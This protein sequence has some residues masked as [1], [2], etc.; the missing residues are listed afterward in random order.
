[1]ILASD[2][3]PDMVSVVGNSNAAISECSGLFQLV[4]VDKSMVG[5]MAKD[6]G[7]GYPGW[8]VEARWTLNPDNQASYNY[9]KA[10]LDN[11]MT[12][13]DNGPRVHATI[14]VGGF[15]AIPSVWPNP[16]PKFQVRL[17]P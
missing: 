10:D 8:P 13:R 17:Y 11:I 14:S 15:G 4:T 9:F 3:I 2:P 6:N 1:M 7:S 12:Q 5:G 16:T